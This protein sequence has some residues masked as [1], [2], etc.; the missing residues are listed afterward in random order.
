MK[1]QTYNLDLLYDL[2]MRVVIVSNSRP[3]RLA[4]NMIVHSPVGIP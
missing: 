3:M 2:T 4:K 1:T